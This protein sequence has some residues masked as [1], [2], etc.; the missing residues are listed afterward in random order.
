M[1]AA[2]RLPFC[3]PV[4]ISRAAQKE[5]KSLAFHPGTRKPRLRTPGCTQSDK[6]YWI[7]REQKNLN[8]IA[9]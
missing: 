5:S 4:I 3:C 2:E 8:D 7:V 9:G 6:V 1:G